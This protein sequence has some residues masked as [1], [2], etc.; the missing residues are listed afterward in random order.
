LEALDN[1][2]VE[3]QNRADPDTRIGGVMLIGLREPIPP[4]GMPGPRERWMS[5]DELPPAVTRKY[6]YTTSPRLS[7]DRC[8]SPQ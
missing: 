7:Q 5:L 2:L 3:A 6:W 8:E 4:L 1:Y